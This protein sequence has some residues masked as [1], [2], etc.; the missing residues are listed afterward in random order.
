M[1]VASNSR[2][3]LRD[4]IDDYH[5]Y[6]TTAADEGF[7]WGYRALH[8]GWR[9]VWHSDSSRNIGQDVPA[10]FGTGVKKKLILFSDSFNNQRFFSAQGSE[11][12]VRRFCRYLTGASPSSPRQPG[13]IEIAIALTGA[14][15][16]PTKGYLRDDCASLPVDRNFLD[17]SNVAEVADFLEGLAELE[18]EVRLVPRP[19]A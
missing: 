11:A 14:Q 17:S 2:Q 19:Q 15:L 12:N 13:D 4:Y 5:G 1:L 9:D 3:E 8:P 18:Y 16:P 10:D 7:A 6:W